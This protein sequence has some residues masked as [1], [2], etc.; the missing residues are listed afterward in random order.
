MVLNGSLQVASALLM[1]GL[2]GWTRGWCRRKKH[3]SRNG[4][5]EAQTGNQHHQTPK[6]TIAEERHESVTLVGGALLAAGI[7]EEE[8]PGTVPDL[9]VELSQMSA[10]MSLSCDSHVRKRASLDAI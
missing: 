7:P 3:L 5:R 8:P 10:T 6:D 1:V 4:R 2:A 9:A